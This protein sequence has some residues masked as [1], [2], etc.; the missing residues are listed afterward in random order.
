MTWWR[1]LTN[2]AHKMLNNIK[3]KKRRHNALYV[4]THTHSE[5]WQSC[6]RPWMI[7]SWPSGP[8]PQISLSGSKS[9]LSLYANQSSFSPTNHGPPRR[10]PSSNH[11][12]P[13]NNALQNQHQAQ[14]ETKEVRYHREQETRWLHGILSA[15]FPYLYTAPRS[16]AARPPPI[17]LV[18]SA[19]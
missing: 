11:G 17:I 18:K 19:D 1:L 5:G 2:S 3:T 10:E 6:D 15:P 12:A 9:G 16:L 8:S 7:T 14:Q 13:A 4:D